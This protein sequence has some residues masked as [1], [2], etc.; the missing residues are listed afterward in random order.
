MTVHLLIFFDFTTRAWYADVFAG[1]EIALGEMEYELA[2][3]YTLVPMAREAVHVYI[4]PML[5]Y[6]IEAEQALLIAW[7]CGGVICFVACIQGIRDIT[8]LYPIVYERIAREG[9][10]SVPFAVRKA[11]AHTIIGMT[12]AYALAGCV[13]MQFCITLT[14]L[15]MRVL[16]STMGVALLARALLGGILIT[17]LADELVVRAWLLPLLLH[18][19]V[20]IGVYVVELYFL[21]V[22]LLKG[23]GVRNGFYM[24]FYLFSFFN[25]HKCAYRPGQ[26]SK[27][28]CHVAFVALIAKQVGKD[29]EEG[30]ASRGGSTHR[31]HA[32]AKRCWWQQLTRGLLGWH[33]TGG[34]GGW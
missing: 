27:D 26:E 12:S 3:W 1:Y 30:G 31:R 25:P 7:S 24:L 33:V 11:D 13:M 16:M 2:S 20:S 10:Q 23:L 8:Q 15:F 29:R 32:A 22:C 19:R 21:F 18:F 6:C 4:R 28:L 17:T 14:T 34:V 5:R 9:T